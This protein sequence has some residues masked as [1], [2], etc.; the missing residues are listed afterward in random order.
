MSAASR[1]LN[2]LISLR[3]YSL[4]DLRKDLAT[5]NHLV[6]EGRES[7]ER[8]QA[9]YRSFVE[10]ARR[11]EENQV[12]LVAGKMLER[13]RY[14]AY[15]QTHIEQA[16]DALSDAAEQQQRAQQAFDDCHTEIR[17]LERVAERRTEAWQQEQQRKI[18]LVADDQ[19]ILRIGRNRS[20]NGA[21]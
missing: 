2:Q 5:L 16:E 10:E 3:R 9:E 11:A 6:Q 18:Y 13:R 15:L 12:A 17:T 7:L 1:A 21:N 14:I 4:E 19:E 8:A 20:A